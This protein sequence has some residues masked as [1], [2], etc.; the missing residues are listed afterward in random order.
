MNKWI[1]GE[2][3]NSAA[4]HRIIERVECDSKNIA[5]NAVAVH[6]I[7]EHFQRIKSV[8]VAI[9]TGVIGHHKEPAARR[10]KLHNGGL[11][12]RGVFNVGFNGDKNSVGGKI[13]RVGGVAKSKPR[14]NWKCFHGEAL[15]H[16][17]NG[18]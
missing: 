16:K 2:R 14:A 13:L 12:G 17:R 6:H 11:L 18:P 4:G 15:L 8:A 3:R 10:D 1:R 7:V 9:G 5:G